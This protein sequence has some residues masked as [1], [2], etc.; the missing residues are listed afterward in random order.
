MGRAKH[1]TPEERRIILE[2]R[3]QNKSYSFIAK[4]IKRSPCVIN[5]VLKDNNIKTPRR[6]N[7]GRPR[8]TSKKMDARIVRESKKNPFLSSSAIKRNLSMTV[9]TRTIRRRLVAQN[10]HGRIARKVPFLR[11]RNVEQRKIFARNN[12]NETNP[13]NWK[14]ILFSDETKINLFGSDGKIY[15]RRGPN[16]EL[17]PRNT[18]GTVKHGGGN[19]KLW[20]AMSYNGVGPIFWIKQNMT[21]EI[22]LEILETIML[23]YAEENMP[24]RW[25]YQQDNDP[26][27]TAYVVKAW[28]AQH[29]V[30]VLDWPSQSP[31]LNPIENL[32]KDL[33][34]RISNKKTSNKNALWEEIQKE[35]YA[36]PVETCRKLID[37][38]P[39]RCK[40]VLKN[41][42]YHTKY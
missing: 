5:K 38:M 4:T 39:R 7:R 27:H 41:N 16:Q 37:S 21:K 12:D 6:E 19:I 30:E 10:L 2:L 18:I 36:T 33:K 29:N 34:S 24:L 20:G 28:F 32:W 31:D 42:G 22:Y 9:S 1:C 13:R 15:V 3:K 8:K 26:K 25:I 23:P 11:K 35:W 17:N 14:N 40:A